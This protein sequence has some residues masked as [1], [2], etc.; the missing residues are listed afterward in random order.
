MDK[1]EFR[2]QQIKI[3][4]EY[5]DS[6]QKINEDQALLESLINTDLLKNSRSIGV[7]SSLSYEVDTAKLIAYLWDLGK[8]VYLARANNDKEHTQD[9]VLYNYMTRVSRSKFGVEEVSDPHAKINNELDLLIVPGLAFTE[10]SNQRL[11]FGGGY[12]DRFLAKHTST[13]TVALANTKMIF[14]SA[15]WEIEATD[16]PIEMIITPTSILQN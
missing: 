2:Q 11:G 9:F 6:E 4:G 14:S 1:K 7:T 5:A 13:K 10:D 12:Y 8:E 16:I 3:L 15:Q